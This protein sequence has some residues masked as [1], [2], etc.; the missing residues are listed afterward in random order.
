[1]EKILD[2]R[3][4]GKVGETL[5]EYITYG[6]KL[7]FISSCFTI[8]AFEELKAELKKAESLRFLFIEPTFIKDNI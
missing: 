5:K 2:N 4:N 8:Y 6:S 3:K 1:L 7:S